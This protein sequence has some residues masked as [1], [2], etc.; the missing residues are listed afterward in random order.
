MDF[1]VSACGK[2]GMHFTFSTVA[3]V[4]WIPSEANGSK[5]PIS[6]SQ[7]LHWICVFCEKQQSVTAFKI[8]V[9]NFPDAVLLTNARVL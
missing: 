5:F 8:Q 2:N 4:G 9:P 7:H 6:K 1:T 3:F